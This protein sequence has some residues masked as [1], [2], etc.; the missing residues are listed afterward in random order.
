M[1]Q[2]VRETMSIVILT[3]SLEGGGAEFV[4]S[5]WALWLGGRGHDVRLLTTS[6]AAGTRLTENVRSAPLASRSHLGAVRR[7]RE[8]LRRE[9]A[10]VVIALQSY[11]N[12]V[13]ITALSLL[14]DRP[15]LIVSERNITTRER[16][17]RD[18]PDRIKRVLSQRLYRRADLVIAV[19]HAVAAELVSAFSVP[20]DRVVVVPN[21][22][23]RS[24]ELRTTTVPADA[25]PVAAA[26]VDDAPLHILLPMRLVPQKRAPLAIA[27]AA[28]LRAEGID[29]RV[30]CFSRGPGMAALE[31][32]AIA[33]GVPLSVPGWTRDWVAAAPPNAVAVLPSY[34]E[35]FGNVLVEAALGGIPSVAVS[36]AYG[37][38]DALVPTVTGDLAFVGTPE[39]LATAIRRARRAS[40]RHVR[41]WAG[42]FSS[43]ESG[44]LL[45]SSIDR[46]TSRRKAAA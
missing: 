32:A 36:N 25:V 12:L 17:P 41:A 4:A 20:G 44:R 40:M 15:T 1:R 14:R 42:R 23:A 2:T 28:Q 34:R 30:V 9:P 18:I 3:T 37:V 33:A 38:A 13:A 19:S 31:S 7:L 39:E 26:V 5:A 46:A 16:E 24:S 45:L 11:P 6:G 8:E 21:P 29:A 35:G 10:D 43:D 27:A 22:S